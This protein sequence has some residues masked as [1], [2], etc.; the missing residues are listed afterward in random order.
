MAKRHDNFFQAPYANTKTKKMSAAKLNLSSGCRETDSNRRTHTHTLT[1]THTQ[2]HTYKNKIQ[3]L[4]ENLM[5][6]GPI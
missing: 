2:T 1:Y 4:E 3:D 5:K 6:N